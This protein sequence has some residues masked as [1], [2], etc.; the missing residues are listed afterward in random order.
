[1][2]GDGSTPEPA[3]LVRLA[4]QLTEA[5]NSHDP[6]RAAAL[7]A[8]DYEGE[9][10]GEAT[11]HRGPDGMAASVATYLAAFPDLSFTVDDVIVQENR[12]VQ[13]W[14][15]QATHRGPLM[16]IPPT[17][18]RIEVRGASVLT[19]RGDKLCRAVYIWDVAGMLRGI[20][21]LPEL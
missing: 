14:H 1:M 6:P 18:L 15:A 9:N 19:F 11:P 10:V 12:V 20:G 17:G 5:W 16:N 7:C 21:L 13:V 8:A 4:A 2:P 3:T